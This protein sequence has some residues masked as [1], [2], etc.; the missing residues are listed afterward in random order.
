MTVDPYA[1][2]RDCQAKT[3]KYDL[4]SAVSNCSLNIDGKFMFGEH[5]MSFQQA[6]VL[7]LG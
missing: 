6:P 1:P 7:R 3:R 2:G 4:P 5:E